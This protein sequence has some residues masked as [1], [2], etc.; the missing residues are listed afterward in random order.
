MYQKSSRAGDVDNLAKF[1][2][3]TLN[4]LVHYEDRR[5]ARLTVMQPLDG[6]G[7][8]RIGRRCLSE[9]PRNDEMR[10][11][12]GA[13]EAGVPSALQLCFGWPN[14]VT[15]KELPVDSRALANADV[16]PVELGYHHHFTPALGI[17]VFTKVHLID[18]NNNTYFHLCCWHHV[19]CSW[20]FHTNTS[21]QRDS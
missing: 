19:F 18:D 17:H 11:T 4:G 13:P 6:E 7:T 12:A 9:R 10:P 2:L 16:Q 14:P 21:S 20:D 3:D 8:C 15:W 5:V 1:V